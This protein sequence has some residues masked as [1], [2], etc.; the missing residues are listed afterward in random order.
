MEERF[1][2]SRHD[3]VNQEKGHEKVDQHL[4]LGGVFLLEVRSTR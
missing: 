4:G 2:E 3:E 1:E